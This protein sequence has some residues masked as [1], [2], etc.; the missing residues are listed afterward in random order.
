MDIEEQRDNLCIWSAEDESDYDS[1]G[2]KLEN[3]QDQTMPG[4]EVH[5][6]ESTDNGK[7]WIDLP[8]FP[9]LMQAKDN[10]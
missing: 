2:Q 1:G 8:Q 5:S 10:L 7:L 4:L 9:H 6:K 3:R